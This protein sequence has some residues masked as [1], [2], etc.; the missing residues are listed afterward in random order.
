MRIESEG[1]SLSIGDRDEEEVAHVYCADKHSGY[2]LSLS[3]FFHND[4]D[5]IDV[6]VYDQVW[7]ST[8]DIRVILSRNEMRVELSP[9]V[10]QRLMRVTDYIVAFTIN[11]DQFNELDAALTV[12]F[13]G[14]NQ[15]R[16][17]RAF[18]AD[19]RIG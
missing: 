1:F 14:I 11:D 12:I 13:E 17:D 4:C 2:C 15:S 8:Q 5:S 19:P 16:Y 9:S 18:N 10:A 7:C 3:R 6:M